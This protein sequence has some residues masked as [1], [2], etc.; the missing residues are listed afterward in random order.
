MKPDHTKLLFVDHAFALGG[1]EKSLLMLMTH[2]D[3]S[4]WQ[5][6]L[7]CP[8]G[9]LADEAETLGIK[10]YRTPIP[11]LRH[12]PRAITDLVC[13]A[14]SIANLARDIRARCIVA[15]T[16][17]AAIYVSLASHL[18]DLPF[19]WYR[20]D[21][22]LGEDPP[23]VSI[24]DSLG[25][26]FLCAMATRIVANSQT[27]ARHLP[28]GDRVSII[29]NGIVLDDF[30]TN[31]YQDRTYSKR[32][33]P[34]RN[35]VIG[36]V[37]RLRPW[38]GQDRFLR[39]LAQVTAIVPDVKG[40]I[41]GGNPFGDGDGYLRV[42]QR[43]SERLGLTSD[44]RFTGHVED[45]RPAIA[46]MDLFVHSG[47]PEPFGL[48]NIEAMAMGKPVVAFAHG[49][50]PE[51]VVDGKTGIL[52]PPYDETAMASAIARLLV[53]PDRRK[54]MGIEARRRVEREFAI[55]RTVAEFS[56]LVANL[57]R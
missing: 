19:L 23:S 42:L 3:S 6:C 24:F 21:F 29:Y 26:V 16:T 54:T 5:T 8:S 45:P 9:K 52:V 12:S 36:T 14:H 43:E 20:R 17:R 44:V 55:E 50:L 22:W 7:A 48:V 38:K 46:T 15:N 37:G 13:Q 1:A 11:R 2:L 28:C 51:I 56:S 40:L 30:T 25:K 39:V 57:V 18:A 47:D 10:I 41:V 27:T 34:D 33:R 35:Y 31:S 32:S 53:D 49:A 4:V